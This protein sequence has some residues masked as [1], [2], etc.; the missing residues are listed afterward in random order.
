M[1]FCTVVEF[2]WD[3]PHAKTAFESMTAHDDVP[4]DVPGRL[5]RI[6]GIDDHGARAIE[7]WSTHEDA[8]RFAESSH[9]AAS[10]AKVP[11]PTRVYGFKVTSF[12][13]A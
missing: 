7:V 4:M 12:D 2:E 11:A 9:A 10:V 13:V 5:A 8:Q 1:A 6:V 3:G